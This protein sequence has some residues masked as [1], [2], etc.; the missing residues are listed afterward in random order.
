MENSRSS[1]WFLTALLYIAVGGLATA[2]LLFL[3][4]ENPSFRALFY[5]QMSMPSGLEAE[6]SASPEEIAASVRAVTESAAKL[7]FGV[8]VFIL[9][10]QVFAF[11]TAILVFSNLK[12]A[13][14]PI[15]IRLKKLENADLFLDLPLYFGLFGTVSSFVIM[16]FNPHVSR[17]IAYSSTLVGIIFSVILRIALLYP[18]RQKFI[19]ELP[20]DFEDGKGVRK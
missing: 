16:S 18:L 14:D 1:K 20:S 19:A 2:V 17:L 3:F 10:L 13:D 6:A 4:R 11:L 15:R 9:L 8:L 12:K 7:S 5:D